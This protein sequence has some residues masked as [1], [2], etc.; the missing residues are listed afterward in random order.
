MMTTSSGG[1]LGTP[2]TRD[3]A[4]R[5]AAAARSTRQ[6]VRSELAAGDTTLA[7]LL[8]AAATDPLVG[9]VKLLWALESVPGARKVDT[10]RRL[11]TLGIVASAP[12][13]QLDAEQRAAVLA[14][15]DRVVDR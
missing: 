2:G 1:A 7:E 5:W 14:N 12:M 13:S 10:R 6:T 4:L 8:T 11:A 9:Q 15:F 3:A